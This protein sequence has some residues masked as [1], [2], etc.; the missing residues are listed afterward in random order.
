VSRESDRKSAYSGRKRKRLAIWFG[1]LRRQPS[2]ASSTCDVGGLRWEESKEPHR[3]K[4]QGA[5][6][7]ERSCSGEMVQ[8]ERVEIRYKGTAKQTEQC[9][10][11]V[12]CVGV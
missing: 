11:M 8:I 10:L 2:F 1:V 4:Q 9:D 7:K 6:S 12:L 3:Q 5:L